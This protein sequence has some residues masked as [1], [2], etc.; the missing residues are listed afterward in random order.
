M[1]VYSYWVVKL[2]KSKKESLAF[3]PRLR[4]TVLGETST[5]SKLPSTRSL[6][7]ANLAE[8][9]ECPE[10]LVAAAALEHNLCRRADEEHPAF[11]DFLALGSHADGSLALGADDDAG[12]FN[13]FEGDFRSGGVEV[14]FHDGKFLDG[15]VVELRAGVGG[16]GGGVEFTVG[17]V[18]WGHLLLGDGREVVGEHA[19]EGGDVFEFGGEACADYV[20][21]G[22][23]AFHDVCVV[24]VSVVGGV[25]G[26]AGY[27]PPLM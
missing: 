7:L 24:V 6:L 25:V 17:E 27:V 18:G 2:L 26:F 13:A 16:V 14:C 1:L 22:G 21:G 3:T 12:A 15:R 4:L 11:A 19:G 10:R 20:V 23:H 9:A 5:T 8:S